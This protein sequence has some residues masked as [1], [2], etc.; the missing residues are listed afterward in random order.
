MY[1]GL[2]EGARNAPYFMGKNLGEETELA[3]Q[4]WFN[5][6]LRNSQLLSCTLVSRPHLAGKQIN[7][8]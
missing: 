5:L 8:R 3:S 2:N 1:L 6:N 4:A 7:H